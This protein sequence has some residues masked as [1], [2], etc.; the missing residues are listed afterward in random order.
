M[1][2]YSGQHHEDKG[3]QEADR[4]EKEQVMRF[5]DAGKLHKG[6]EV[7]VKETGEVINVVDTFVYDDDEYKLVMIVAP[8]GQ[9]YS[10]DEVM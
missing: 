4:F 3:N 1:R 9:E 6:D 8:D 10:H 2:H 5:R 7:V